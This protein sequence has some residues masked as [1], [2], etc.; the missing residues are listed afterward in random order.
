MCFAAVPEHTLRQAIER[1][2]AAFETIRDS[3]RC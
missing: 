1:I 2:R 3:S